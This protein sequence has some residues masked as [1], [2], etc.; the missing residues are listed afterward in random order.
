MH[1]LALLRTLALA[2]SL[3][4]VLACRS[5]EASSAT[6][7]ATASEPAQEATGATGP[8]D[9]SAAP[10]VAQAAEVGIDTYPALLLALL[11]PDERARLVGLAQ[12]ELCPCEGQ[13]SS[14]D[15]CL[16]SIETTCML[17]AQA[18]AVMMRMIKEDADD[19]EIGAAVQAY[20]ANARRVVEFDL[21][22]V[23]W[24]GA[25][26]P[27]ITLVEFADFQCPHCRVF[28]ESLREVTARFGDRVR[29]YYRHF[30]LP[31]HQNAATAALAA[32]AAGRQDRFWEFHDLVFANQAALTAASDP[33]P[34]LVG[35]AEQLGLNRQRFLADM[36]SPEV[37]ALVEADRAAGE[38]AMLD[39]T[40]TLYIDGVRMLDGY[41]TE[42]IVALIA[43]R[44]GT[45][46]N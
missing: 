2:V 20:V 37:A 13:V 46:A 5:P 12:T 6:Q 31:S 35:W 38:Q 34:L 39:G 14:L 25:E 40:P 41:D 33:I 30:P 29:I 44:L 22:N 1:R 21:T 32:T 17:A 3:L 18:G 45:P 36:G 4:A 19:T 43:Q 7:P 26:T 24:K 16:R 15:A 9:G 10:A 28:A 42:S 27:Q 23:P 8:A 11:E